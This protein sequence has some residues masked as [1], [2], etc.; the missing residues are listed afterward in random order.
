MCAV[1]VLRR[2][3][4]DTTRIKCGWSAGAARGTG[5]RPSSDRAIIQKLGSVCPAGVGVLSR[6]QDEEGVRICVEVSLRGALI[7]G[8]IA[9][10]AN[11]ILTTFEAKLQTERVC[12]GKGSVGFLGTAPENLEFGVRSSVSSR[13]TRR[14]DTAASKTLS[15][16]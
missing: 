13:P 7:I 6:W 14:G 2:C 16:S 9:A 11:T 8:R 5:A 15:D 3:G 10:K 4:H 1:Q 12:N